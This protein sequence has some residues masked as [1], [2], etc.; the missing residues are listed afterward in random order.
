MLIFNIRTSSKCINGLGREIIVGAKIKATQLLKTELH[1]TIIIPNLIMKITTIIFAISSLALSA[2][3][4]PAPAPEAAP[5]AGDNI[6]NRDLC[7][8]SN[9]LYCC[10]NLGIYTCH[11]LLLVS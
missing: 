6:L 8:C 3:A 2:M 7:F 4:A 11:P 9:D 10:P 1:T 5:F